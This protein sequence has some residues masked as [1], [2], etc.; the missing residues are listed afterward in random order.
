MR[1]SVKNVLISGSSKGLG[2]ELSIHLRQLGMNVITMGNETKADVD[3]RCDLL[4]V[5]R[6]K[7]VFAEYFK[8][9]QVL[10]IVVCN[11]GTGK[12]PEAVMDIQELNLY[13]LEKNFSTAS[14]LIDCVLP[15]LRKHE[16]SI[17]GISSIVAMK[18]IK[19][20]PTGYRI[21][22]QKLN[23]LFS[24]KAK[25]FAKDGIRFNVISPGNV[26]FKGGRWEEIEKEN[27]ALVEDLLQNEV[28]LG[29]FIN[30]QEISD[31]IVYLSSRS[32]RNVTGS[33]LVI[34]GGQTIA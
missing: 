27:P 6:L 16:S 32:A 3:I 18:E 14:N 12:L 15:Y 29:S 7:E 8:G 10:D 25:Q 11:A 1:S 13:F 9:K 22:K 28:P 26:Y 17:V 21:A 31:A 24:L 2:K 30:P 4:N 33:N 20:A 23:E 34:D 5:S 19:G